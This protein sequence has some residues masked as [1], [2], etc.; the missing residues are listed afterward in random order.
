LVGADGATHAG[1]YD[2][3]F[4][5]CI[6]NMLLMAPADEAECRDLLTTA[7]KQNHPSAVRYP[8]GA[9][10]GAVVSEELK[11]LPLGKG[12]IRRTT[13]AKSSPKIAILAFGTL[14][15]P[16][17]E[18]AEILDAT[19]ANMRFIKPLDVDLVCELAKTHDLIVTLEEGAIGGGAG[20]ACLEALSAAG[21]EVPSLIL[22]LPDRFVDHG[23]HAL[24]MK[25]CGLDVDGI[26][27]SIALK[28][29]IN[30]KK[31]AA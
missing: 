21:I 23:D 2:I 13:T 20:S 25:E 4:I 18:V 30:P 31:Q 17:L 3:P 28:L 19:V 7:F 22:G 12:E 10:V 8:R 15:Y 11:E 6:P 9:G 24:L 26:T 14:L 5:R 27:K 1:V 29:G 16:A